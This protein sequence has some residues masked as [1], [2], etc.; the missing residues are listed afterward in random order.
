MLQADYVVKPR[1][2]ITSH[3]CWVSTKY[4]LI[5]PLSVIHSSAVC[6]KEKYNSGSFLQLNYCS[7]RT[8]HIDEEVSL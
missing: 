7:I 6:K 4:F 8:G 3:Y 1:A 5:H 2:H